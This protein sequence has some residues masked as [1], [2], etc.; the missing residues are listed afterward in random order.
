METWLIVAAE[1]REFSGIVKR[2][3]HTRPLRCPGAAFAREITW[4]GMRWALLAN[5]PGP[6]LAGRML[7]SPV[8]AGWNVRQVISTGFCGALDPALHVGDIVVSGEGFEGA[9]GQFFRGN[10]WSADQV[11]VTSEEKL[12]LRQSTGACVVEMESAAVAEKANAWGL[13]FRAVKVVSDTADEDLALDFN[14]YRDR[15]GRFQVP[16]IAAAA[17][18]HPF[19]TLPALLRL[20]RNCQQ[21]AESLG[22]FFA[23]CE[24]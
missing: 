16:R 21:A 3:S 5:G 8:I 19:T 2:A 1:A 12:K 14:Q 13:P 4:R 6:Q 17:L 24:F 15:D 22:E 9:A 23:H 11:A 10:I 20:H 18:T 7:S